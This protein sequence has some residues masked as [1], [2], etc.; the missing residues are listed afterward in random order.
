M[1]VAQGIFKQLSYKKQAALGSAASGGSGQLLRRESATF[2][3]MKGAFNSNEITSHQNYTGD[4]YGASKTEG[5][6]SGVLSPLTYSVLLASLLRKDL[7][8]TSALTGLSLTIAGSGPFTITRGSGDFL[9]SGIKQGDVIR[10]TAGTYTG[11]ARDLN[12]LVT[13]ASSSALTVIVP[14]GKVLDAQGP[15]TSSTITIIGKRSVA[16]VTSQTNDYYTFE[17]WQTGLSRSRLW[18]DVQIASAEIAIPA[19]GNASINL[20]CLGLG[21]TRAGS[22]VLT[23][24]SAETTTS[25]L[26]AVNAAILVSGSRTVVG[27]SLNMTIDGQLSHGEEVIG[28]QVLSDIVKGDIKVSGS[29]S[30]LNEGETYGTLFDN[31]S[32]ASIIAVLFADSSDTSAFVGFSIPRAKLFSD[33]RDDGKKQLVETHTFTAEYNGGSGGSG[34]ITEAGCIT[35]Q[36]SAA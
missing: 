17:E 20:S 4:S 29:F 12:L 33:E 3:K 25:I 8:T 21:L 22:Q 7:A 10:I 32:A 1:A 13:T 34:T 23:S 24:P 30:V 5:R 18:T 16:A 19:S 31:E 28:S 2:T 36:D 26:S 6:I 14:N 27:T 11:I 9:A 35:Y 15:I